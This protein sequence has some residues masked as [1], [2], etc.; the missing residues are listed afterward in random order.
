MD[1]FFT[2]IDNRRFGVE[3]KWYTKYLFTEKMNWSEINNYVF[4]GI[5]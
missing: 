5:I 1:L 3:N 2:T 4:E